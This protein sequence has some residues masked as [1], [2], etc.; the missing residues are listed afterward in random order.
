MV[1][2]MQRDTAVVVGATGA[3]G[4][5]IC[6][7]LAREGLDVVAVA[8][9][10]DALGSLVETTPGVRACVA[11][12]AQDSSSEAIRASLGE[13]PVRIVVHG[14]GVATAGG[15]LTAPTAAV[16]DAVNIKVG[17]MLRLV[18]AVDAQLQ[19]GS[20]LIGIGGHYGFE[21]TAYAATAGV[22]NAALANL[23]RQLSWAYGSR[24]VTAHLLAPGPADTERL[25]RV[26]ASR[27]GRDG[28]VAED[29]LDEM[30]AESAIGAFTTVEQIAWAVATLLAPEAD[31]LAGG[32]LFLD[33]GRRKG[34]P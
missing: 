16:V 25:R 3:M 21:P 11:D 2:S 24:G 23:M 29:V 19:R 10:A 30:R 9:S 18:R 8:R 12:I 7:R 14:P 13:G 31:A 26:A 34:M 1:T 22:C 5:V 15:V 17:G 33:A 32:T 27:A 4:E 6:R 20:R 28:T